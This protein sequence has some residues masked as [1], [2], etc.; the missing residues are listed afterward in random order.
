MTT[1]KGKTRN[2]KKMWGK[3][4]IQKRNKDFFFEKAKFVKKRQKKQARNIW[5]IE[6]KNEK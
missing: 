5:E 1:N 2:V 3:K 4:F 6:K